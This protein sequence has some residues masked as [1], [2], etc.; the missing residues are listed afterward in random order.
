MSKTWQKD[1]AINFIINH[2]FGLEK[3]FFKKNLF[4]K[5]IN[6]I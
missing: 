6:L 2:L 5:Q 1:Y 3:D 4:Y